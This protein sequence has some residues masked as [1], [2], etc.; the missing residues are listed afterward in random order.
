VIKLHEG[1]YFEEDDLLC[2]ADKLNV[3]SIKSFGR[4]E[5]EKIVKLTPLKK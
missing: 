1:H 4:L 2:E 3:R 5:H